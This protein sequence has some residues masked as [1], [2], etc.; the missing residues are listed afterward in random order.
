MLNVML[1]GSNIES[2]SRLKQRQGQRKKS[3]AVL[4]FI[5]LHHF[6]LTLLF[7]SMDLLQ[8]NT[9]FK[10]YIVVAKNYAVL[11]FCSNFVK[12]FT[13]RFVAGSANACFR[14]L[15]GKEHTYRVLVGRSQPV[16][17]IYGAEYSIH[18]VQLYLSNY[19]L[20]ELFDF[21]YM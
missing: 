21:D 11:T 16:V 3:I 9:L 7:V 12:W 10:K 17:I 6:C 4:F 20:F 2:R 8:K 13:N 14:A 15:V 1:A 18:I 19:L 5:Y